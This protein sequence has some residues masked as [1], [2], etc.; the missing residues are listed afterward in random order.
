MMPSPYQL[1]RADRDKKWLKGRVH[2]IE[3]HFF[4]RGHRPR[5][6]EVIAHPDL[7]TPMQWQNLHGGASKYQP[8]KPVHLQ[9]LHRQLYALDNPLL[10]F[11]VVRIETAWFDS[12]PIGYSVRFSDPEHE[13]LMV[14]KH[15]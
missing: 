1:L 2:L 6:V 9:A 4:H 10:R 11:S 15:T 3:N 5:I 7:F 13:M 8:L 14:M 12:A